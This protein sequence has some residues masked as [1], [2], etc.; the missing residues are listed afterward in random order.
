M[1]NVGTIAR[2]VAETVDD[3]NTSDIFNAATGG[4]ARALRRDDIGRLAV[5]ARADLV[6]VHLTAPSMMP[7][8]EP[9]RPRVFT[10]CHRAVKDVFVDGQQVVRDGAEQT[11]HLRRPTPR[12]PAP[13]ARPLTTPP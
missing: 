5:G 13:P 1:R 7:V 11:T 4:G 12:T 2:A 9:I 3:L 6:C 8:R 10:A